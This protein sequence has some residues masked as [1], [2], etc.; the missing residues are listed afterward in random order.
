MEK[1]LKGRLHTHSENSVKDAVSKVSQMAQKAKE[2]GFDALALTDH[3]TLTGWQSFSK[4]CKKEGIKPIFGCEMYVKSILDNTNVTDEDDSNAA[5]LSGKADGRLHLIVLAKDNIGLQAISLMVTESNLHI[6]KRGKN[7]YPCIDKAILE[8]YIGPGSAGFRH[9]VMT[10]ACIGGVLAGLAFQN[11]A[12]IAEAQK[13]A[14][15]LEYE[16]KLRE[17]LE[18][19]EKE[20]AKYAELR[21]RAKELK[22]KK[23][24]ARKRAIEKREDGPEK[25]QALAELQVEMDETRIAAEQF[26]DIAQK[27]NRFKKQI[28]EC[29][30]R[31]MTSDVYE[32]KTARKDYLDSQIMSH[33]DLI[34]KMEDEALYYD[35]MAGHG[36]FFIE[37]QYHGSP[38]EKL[39]MPILDK[40]AHRLSI[41]TIAAN[42]EHM[43]SKEDVEARKFLN[44]M[45][46]KTFR[47][48]EPSES[49]Y[50]VYF[51]S[52]EELSD[53]LVSAI[54]SKK[55]VQEAF[56]GISTVIAMCNAELTSEKH[57]PKLDPEL[58][59]KAAGDKL[60]ALARA[61]IGKY[62]VW[63]D[64]LEKRLSYE[65]SVI[66][67]M[68][69]A[70]YF[71]IVQWYINVGRKLGHMPEARFEFL[72]RNVRAMELDDIMAYIDEDQSMPGYAVG[73]GRG[74]GAGSLMCYLTG[75]TSIDP[76]KNGLVFER[77]LNPERISMPDIDADFANFIRDLLIEIVKKKFGENGVCG[78]M[79]RGTLAAKASIQMV[80]KVYG[81]KMK[82][83]SKAYIGLSTKMSKIIPTAP[84][85]RIED[86]EQA[87]LDAFK[88]TEDEEAVTGILEIAKKLEGVYNN[89]GQHAA[90]VVI[91]DNGDIRQYTPLM[92]DVDNGG[93][94][95]QMD[96]D[97]VEKNGMLKMDF[98]GLKNLD[99]ITDAIRLIYK[100]HGVL[101]DPENIPVTDEV[102][103]LF[104]D[105]DT[106]S[107]FQFESDGMKKMLGQF[108]PTTFDDLVLLVAAYRPG[109]MQFLPEVFKVKNGGKASYLT[110]K[111][112][113]ILENTYGQIIYQEQV[114]QIFRDLAGYSLGG[115]DL[116]RRAMGHKEM[117]LLQKERE[118]FV[119]GDAS[120]NI[121]GCA[122]NGIDE[123]TA[124]TLFDQ[125]MKFAEYAFNKSHAAVYAWIAYITA[126]L[127]HYYAP[128][129]YCVVM[130]YE[131]LE[132]MPALVNDCR[133]NHTEVKNPDINLSEVALSIRDHSIYFGLGNIKDVAA[134]AAMIVNEREANG[135][136][137]SI[138]DFIIRTGC[139]KNVFES[140]AKAGAFDSL[141]KYRM[142]LYLNAD[143]IC[144]AGKDVNKCYAEKQKKVE[145]LQLME[146]G[147]IEEATARNN[148][149]K[150]NVKTLVKSISSL[151]T[152]I[153]EARRILN[154]SNVH[155]GSENAIQLLNMEREVIGT[156]LSGSPLD[157]YVPVACDLRNKPLGPELR[158]NMSVRL[159]SYPEDV[160]TLTQRK[161]GKQFATMK[162]QTQY[163][164]MNGICFEE[165]LLADI[166]G[167][168]A[169]LVLEGKLIPDREDESLLQFRVSALYPAAALYNDIYV[170]VKNVGIW[171]DLCAEADTENRKKTCRIIY[172]FDESTDE[173][174]VSNLH[175][176]SELVK[177]YEAEGK[178]T[179]YPVD[180]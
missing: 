4:A 139:K 110:Q 23:Y 115:A 101:I 159:L 16:A 162:L 136:F 22:D 82:G 87:I 18:Y 6:E 175:A 135:Q 54:G 113:P 173:R 19:A 86:Y 102:I 31:M 106:N 43:I 28:T 144:S 57:Y 103:K 119:H 92:W 39:W 45:R 123:K 151:H 131:A 65:L 137:A 8:K 91:A 172:Y 38:E 32:Y 60:E 94:K 63:T 84:N 36:N 142:D 167:A 93:W 74:S 114:M 156:Y 155:Y 116:V 83:D 107:V 163:G 130:G 150:P 64:E 109:P 160:K 48:E 128:E 127:K 20:E 141:Y 147:S 44:S 105:G 104:A 56:E 152:K 40:I 100:R 90:G 164:I 9:V 154:R 2:L 14:E 27:H 143:I 157:G 145:L 47:Y 121:A 170:S 41:P 81:N 58:D 35:I 26:A 46:F 7:V 73:P 76:I 70:D 97:E 98:L 72:K 179:T 52:D 169:P 29:R 75:I 80:A 125:M 62:P 140:L 69:F 50:E 122:A 59:E 78:I 168:E 37:L 120:R 24:T 68:G 34:K 17:T 21:A 126:Y 165:G 153:E 171:C 148:G 158:P 177:R 134:S 89:T 11:D 25:D 132:K 61:N 96:K 180:F 133:A 51:K 118:A 1:L 77:F 112:V 12:Y 15:D 49:D 129:F 174:R 42:D 111:L 10:S 13:L 117:D 55:H 66:R 53:F 178:L 124:N 3:G 33:D 30:E 138:A 71:L 176:S 85:T 161:N 108:G 95:S 146:A 99:I 79:T 149:K 166:I 5:H 67:S 88:G